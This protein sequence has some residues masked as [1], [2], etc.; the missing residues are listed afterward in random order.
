MENNVIYLSDASYDHLTKEAG[1]GGKDES[2]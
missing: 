2:L 1:I